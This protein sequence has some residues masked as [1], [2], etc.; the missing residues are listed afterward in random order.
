MFP[1]GHLGITL[2]ISLAL[3]KVRPVLA[4]RVDIRFVLIGAV[5]PDIVDKFLGHV[6]LAGTLDN[7]RLVGHTA[8]FSLA[9]IAVGMVLASDRLAVIGSAG[10]VHLGLDLM[11]YLPSTLFWPA[12]GVTFP[13]EG[14]EVYDWLATLVSDPFVQ[15]GEIVG[16]AILLWFVLWHGLYRI[17]R[18]RLF[19]TRGEL[20]AQAATS[21]AYQK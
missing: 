2:G 20:N 15:M 6:V 18:I 17:E 19:L 7:G 10:G 3:I 4:S 13:A 1:L 11:W 8:A 21:A 12:Y 14:F 9:F 16:G 5:L